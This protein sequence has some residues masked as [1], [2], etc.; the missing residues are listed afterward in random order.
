M[1]SHPPAPGSQILDDYEEGTWTP[2]LPGGGTV[3]TIN[4]ARY[5]KIGGLVQ[6]QCYIVCGGI[7][8]NGT[9]FQ[10]GG[11]PYTP[12]Q[13]NAFGGGTIQYGAYS[14]Y[15]VYQNPI[16]HASHNYIYFHRSDGNASAVTNSIIYAN[17]GSQGAGNLVL[18]LNVTF[19]HM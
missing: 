3:N 7:P 18:I 15:D 13:S 10:I 8:N 17:A 19:R 2:T 5:T 1:S 16:V 6:A 14:N 9:Q 4:A 12:N 11:L